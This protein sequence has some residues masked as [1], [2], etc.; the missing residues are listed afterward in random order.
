MPVHDAK[1]TDC[2]A[3]SEVRI[4]VNDD[5]P[6][7]TCSCGGKI[8]KKFSPV[9]VSFKGRGFYTTDK[10]RRVSAKAEITSS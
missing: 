8:V 2:G 4:G 5:F 10:T 7:L 3:V 9:A 1:C 6:S